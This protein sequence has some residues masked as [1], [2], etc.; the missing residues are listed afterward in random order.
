M[1]ILADAMD[2]KIQHDQR[3]EECGEEGWKVLSI[4]SEKDIT[5]SVH[6]DW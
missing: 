5:F 4:C 6:T 2:G 3:R 1:T